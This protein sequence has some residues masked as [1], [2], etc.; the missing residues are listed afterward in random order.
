MLFVSEVSVTTS[1]LS[2]MATIYQVP[3]DVPGGIVTV[4][5]PELVA[6]AANAGT[7]RLPIK[8]SEASMLVFVDK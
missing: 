4:V 3:T 5:E 7:F 6:P 2:A 1:S 8:V